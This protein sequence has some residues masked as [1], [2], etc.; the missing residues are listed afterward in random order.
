MHIAVYFSFRSAIYCIPIRPLQKDKADLE[1]QTPFLLQN[2]KRIGSMINCFSPNRQ[3][4]PHK[5]LTS[6]PPILVEHEVF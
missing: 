4:N 6:V 1:K 5:N 2:P 3:L